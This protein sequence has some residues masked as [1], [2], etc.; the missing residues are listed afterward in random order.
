M[1]HNV[2]LTLRYMVRQY[3]TPLFG[4]HINRTEHPPDILNA[5]IVGGLIR[6][7]LCRTGY[8]VTDKG[9]SIAEGNSAPA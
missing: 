6:L 3:P 9:R 4:G 7:S 1:R 5:L 2:A 8:V